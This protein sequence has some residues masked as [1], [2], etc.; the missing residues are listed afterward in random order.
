MA[1]LRSRKIR[2]VSSVRS[3]NIPYMRAIPNATSL[4]TT[5]AR[6]ADSAK[7]EERASS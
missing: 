5:M 1:S 7:G 4:D 6:R 3:L 2:N